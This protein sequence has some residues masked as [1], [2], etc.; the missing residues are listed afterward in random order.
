MLL[1]LEKNPSLRLTS[2][3]ADDM[4]DLVV[5]KKSKGGQDQPD[6]EAEVDDYKPQVEKYVIV[7]FKRL[8]L[9]NCC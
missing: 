6:S 2:L 8:S 7:V 9:V 3:N 4:A 5:V 1:L